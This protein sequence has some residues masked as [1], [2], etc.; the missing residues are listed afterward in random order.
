[1]A[2]D[3]YVCFCVLSSVSLIHL[4]MLVHFSDGSVTLDLLCNLKLGIGIH[5]L[6]F[7]LGSTCGIW[8]LLYISRNFKIIFLF[9]W[10]VSWE[11]SLGFN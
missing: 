9:L 4:S 3:V 6:A 10:R 1:M 11:V 8:V 7:S 5:R 2:I